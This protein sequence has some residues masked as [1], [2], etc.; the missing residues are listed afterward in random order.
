MEADTNKMSIRHQPS[1]TAVATAFMRALASH[2]EREEI[3]GPDYLAE[4]FLTEDRKR[5]LRDPKVREWVIKNKID[6]GTYEFMI[7]RTA[8]F[9]HLVQQ[10]LRVNV[11]QVVF[12]GAGYDTRPYRLKDLIQGTKIFELDAQPTQQRKKDTLDQANV[13]IPEQVVFV[14]INFETGN[15][16]GALLG[17][18]FNRGQKTLF[19]WEGVT[20]YLSAEAVDRTLSFIRLNSSSGSSIC[21]DYASLSSEALNEN[22]VKKLRDRMK[23]RYAAEPARFGITQGRLASFLTESGYDILEHLTANDMQCRYLTLRDGSLVGIVPP[24]FCLVHASVSPQV[25]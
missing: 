19:V 7:A 2:D 12:L 15:L 9:D 6:P 17:A 25:H 5:L 24:L 16:K 11:P 3:K 22:G 20:Y 4:I 23:S 13:T 10:A 1:E 18:G 21:F 8:F 14:P